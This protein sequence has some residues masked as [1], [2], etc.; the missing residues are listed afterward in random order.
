MSRSKAE[1]ADAIRFMEHHLGFKMEDWQKDILQT[2]LAKES[3]KPERYGVK[4]YPKPQW[5]KGS[6]WPSVTDFGRAEPY[7][8]FTEKAREAW[9]FPSVAAADTEAHR[10]SAKLGLR[11]EVVKL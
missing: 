7:D 1:I 5:L 9:G 8:T 4:V 2:L 3:P 6:S 10:I 11:C